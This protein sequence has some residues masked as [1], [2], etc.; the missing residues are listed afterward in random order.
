MFKL[1]YNMISYSLF[2]LIS[3]SGLMA[4]E[5]ASFEE[6]T[7]FGE[8]TDLLEVRLEDIVSLEILPWMHV[9]VNVEMSGVN[10]N[11]VFDGF[12]NLQDK[13]WILL[14]FHVYGNTPAL[15]YLD[16]SVD[17]RDV[18]L[19]VSFDTVDVGANDNTAN[20]SFVPDY[21]TYP[22][23]IAT[24]PIDIINHV[25]T[26]RSGLIEIPFYE[27]KSDIY[28]LCEV[29]IGSAGIYNSI[30]SGEYCITIT[31]TIIDN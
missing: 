18:D 26:T 6:R 7:A 13:D 22:S 28:A 25:L 12:E 30:P 1:F 27:E 23:G 9:T 20:P 15:M 8:N 16:A 4:M 11:I 14:K 17:F 21:Q 31:T 10:E 19:R 29:Q 5:P 2:L 24:G 3:F